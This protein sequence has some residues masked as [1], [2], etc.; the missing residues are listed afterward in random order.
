[1]KAIL[2]KNYPSATVILVAVFFGLGPGMRAQP[3]S[4]IDQ[5]LT[6][7]TRK[8]SQLPVA[9]HFKWTAVTVD[10]CTAVELHFP[11]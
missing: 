5:A 9:P 7:Q 2:L 3:R 4:S 8:E 6:E 1:M 10:L 11:A